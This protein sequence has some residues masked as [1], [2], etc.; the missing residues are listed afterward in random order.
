[1]EGAPY[2]L[3]LNCYSPEPPPAN[4]TCDGAACLPPGEDNGFSG[5]LMWANDEFGSM[6]CDGAYADGA[7]VYYKF[8]LDDGDTFTAEV[9][10][11]PFTDVTLF[12]VTDCFAPEATCV[13]GVDVGIPG[14]PET[15]SY[16]QTSGGPTAYYLMVKEY[17]SSFYQSSTFTGVYSHDGLMCDDPVPTEETTWGSLKAIFR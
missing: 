10:G 11:D 13:A 7:D 4:D 8:G 6:G 15:I 3:S 5:S 1:M 9:D 2:T 16:S 14:D 12:I 17:N